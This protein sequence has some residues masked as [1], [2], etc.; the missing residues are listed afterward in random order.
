MTFYYVF[1]VTLATCDKGIDH[2]H[3]VRRK[4][5]TAGH[6]WKKNQI[7]LIAKAGKAPTLHPAFSGIIDMLDPHDHSDF[8]ADDDSDN[9]AGKESTARKNFTSNDLEKELR[10]ILGDEYDEAANVEVEVSVI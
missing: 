4:K 2:D 5:W 7:W 9:E 10:D 3:V 8:F 1:A 6:V